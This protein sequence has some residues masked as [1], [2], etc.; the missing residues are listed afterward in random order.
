MN[1]LSI[2][3]AYDHAVVR[4]GLKAML[5]QHND[6][7]V[8]GEAST[9]EEA[10]EQA[11]LCQPDIVVMDIV[12]PGMSDVDAC[13]KIT[14]QLPATRVVMLTSFAEDKRLIAALRAGAASYVLKRIGVDDL[15]RSIQTVVRAINP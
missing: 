4:M 5:H 13:S 3:I 9:G 10:I 15:V 6:L 14:E 8:V 7:C 1:P 11:M 12:L 2:V